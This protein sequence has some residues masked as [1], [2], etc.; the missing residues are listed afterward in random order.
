MVYH[1]P[2]E[3]IDDRGDLA[4]DGSADGGFLEG[5]IGIGCKRAVLQNQVLAIAKGLGAGDAAANQTEVLGVPTEIFAIDLRII[6]GYIL[7][8][9]E[10]ILGIQHGIM[11]L[12]IANVLEGILTL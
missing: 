4:A 5:T 12:D 1:R 2:G 6:E 10:S 8:I 9:P 7:A 11:D 3:R